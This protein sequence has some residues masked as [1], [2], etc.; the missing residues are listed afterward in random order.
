MQIISVHDVVEIKLSA[1]TLIQGDVPFYFSHME[2]TDNTGN[3]TQISF[4]SDLKEN[5]KVELPTE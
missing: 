4:Y 1:T 2:V 5:L 3:T